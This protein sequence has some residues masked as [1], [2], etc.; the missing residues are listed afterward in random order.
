[1]LLC[2]ATFLIQHHSFFPILISNTAGE[3][4]SPSECSSHLVDFIQRFTAGFWCYFAAS[5]VI[6]MVATRALPIRRTHTE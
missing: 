3:Y 2:I 5:V 4:F 1:M 6:A